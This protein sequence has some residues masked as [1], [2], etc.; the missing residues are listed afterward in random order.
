M[1]SLCTCKNEHKS[2]RKRIKETAMIFENAEIPDELRMKVAR[3]AEGEMFARQSLLDE[4]V[5]TIPKDPVVRVWAYQGAIAAGADV[6]WHI[7]NGPLIV[8]CL[9]GEAILQ[10]ENEVMHYKAGDAFIEPVGV[11][12]R[13]Y[14][15][16]PDVPFLGI[17]VQLTPPDRDHV[18]NMG[19]PPQVV[20]RDEL[21]GHV[22]VTLGGHDG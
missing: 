5:T 16:N 4:Q 1:P 7:H 19:E 11:L 20:F 8:V 12:H 18:V 9:E 15:P 22:G 17:S 3:V 6:P 2:S 21:V 10:F 14:N 13:S